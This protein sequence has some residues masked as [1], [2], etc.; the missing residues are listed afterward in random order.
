MPNE[1]SNE[2]STP[3]TSSNELIIKI[4]NQLQNNKESKPFVDRLKKLGDISMNQ[5]MLIAIPILNILNNIISSSLLVSDSTN[6][7]KGYG[8]FNLIVYSLLTLYFIYF[9]YNVKS[10]KKKDLN[11]H[12]IAFYSIIF[13]GLISIIVYC[14]HIKDEN[15]SNESIKGYQIFSN[16]FNALT[17]IVM[18]INKT[19]IGGKSNA[20]KIAA[21]AVENESQAVEN[22]SQVVNEEQKSQQGG[23]RKYKR[24]KYKRRK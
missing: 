18:A 15:T 12:S 19:E 5:N 22:E 21:E 1:G 11:I 6:S 14:F 13:F 8:I 23:K 16:S 20:I 4:G 2:G 17:L 24:R 10:G 3:N 9:G 7:L